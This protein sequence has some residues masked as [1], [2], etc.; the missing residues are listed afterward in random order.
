MW[1][2]SS[3]IEPS[4]SGREASECVDHGR[5]AGSVGTDEREGRPRL[6]G[7]VDPQLEVAASDDEVGGQT[8][9]VGACGRGA[10][11][12]CVMRWR[13]VTRTI[14]ESTTNSND[15][16]IAPPGSVCRAS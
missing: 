15:K 5:L 7:E 11:A 14:N 12:A 8:R 16:K 6:A 13:I 9:S 3:T 2:P 4:V 1:T 10:H